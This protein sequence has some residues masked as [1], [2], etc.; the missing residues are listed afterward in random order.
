MLSEPSTQLWACRGRH[1][2][3]HARPQR[4]S[5]ALALKP[6]L[7]CSTCSTFCEE[8]LKAH[9]RGPRSMGTPK[10]IFRRVSLR[11]RGADKGAVSPAGAELLPRRE[12]ARA[13]R[14]TLSPE[15]VRDS[16]ECERVKGCPQPAPVPCDTRL[17]GLE[18]LLIMYVICLW[19]TVLMFIQSF[20][21]VYRN[22]KRQNEF[23]QSVAG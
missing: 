22:F 9:A 5:W 13:G 7:P 2:I 21:G 10:S 23:Y 4:L 14:Q 6:G 17:S 15:P 8:E 12:P 18:L 1:A 19:K 20:N 16:W 3:T 11:T